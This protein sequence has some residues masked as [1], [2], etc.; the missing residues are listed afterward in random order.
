MLPRSL[1]L[2][3]LIATS[4]TIFAQHYKPLDQGSK[5][6]FTIKNFGIGTGGD[7]SG[8]NGIIDFVPSNLKACLF[9]VSVDV[10]TIDTD[11]GT[12]DKHLRSADY[13]DADKFPKIILKSTSVNLTTPKTANMYYFTGTLT[14]HGVTKVIE[15]PF[16]ASTQGKD[17][18]FKGDFDINRTD[19]GVGGNGGVLGKTVKVSLVVF[20][21][22]R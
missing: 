16:T 12:R 17:L 8:L 10:K 7:L 22:T 20:A 2:I 5:V 19:F 18:L 14:I 9:N 11:N 21:K 13:F 15:F 4:Q 3:F 1:P 6:H